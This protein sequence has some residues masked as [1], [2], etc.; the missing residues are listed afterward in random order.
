MRTPGQK[1]L[2]FFLSKANGKIVS[3][4]RGI[5][6]LITFATTA[7]PTHL[8]NKTNRLGPNQNIP[9]LRKWQ[10]LGGNLYPH[11][12]EKEGHCDSISLIPWIYPHPSQ[13][14]PTGSTLWAG[15]GVRMLLSSTEDPRIH[16]QWCSEQNILCFP[17]A[18]YYCYFCSE[19]NPWE[20]S[21]L[22]GADPQ[23]TYKGYSA[24]SQG[25]R[26]SIPGTAT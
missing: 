9:S 25:R 11:L 12:L 7:Q 2:I 15:S 24:S 23:G 20:V 4:F 19:R 18:K 3:T 10:G 6:V 16:P 1:Q 5:L 13:T 17:M 14:M 26:C 22:I 21:G 8:A